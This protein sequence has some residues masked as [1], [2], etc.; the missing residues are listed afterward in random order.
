M[1]SDETATE[2]ESLKLRLE[3]A[4]NYGQSENRRADA[5]LLR[6]VD[7][8]QV[9]P[10][11]NTEPCHDRC[12]CVHPFSSSGCRRC[13]AHGSRDQRMAK[14]R[15]LAHIHRVYEAAVAWFNNQTMSHD[16]RD[17]KITEDALYNAVNDADNDLTP[18]MPGL[19]RNP[20][21]LNGQ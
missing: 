4:T 12:A 10:C 18:E 1:T 6:M 17:F 16:E 9:C 5:N 19:V 11:R 2:I 14:A 3:L 21:R 20:G 15:H 8:Q 7:A 13:C